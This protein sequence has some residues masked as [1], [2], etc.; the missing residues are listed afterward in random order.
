MTSADADAVTQDFADRHGRPPAGVWVAPGRVNLIGEHTDY[1]DGFVMP[2]ALAQAV[3]VAAAPR[4]DDR[5]SVTS[6]ST[7]ET[8][9]FG[10]D[11]LVPGMS[12][13]QAYVAGVVW[14]LPRPGTPSAGPTW[15]SPPTCRSARACPPP[16]PWS[17][18]CWPPSPTS[19]AWP[20]SRWSGP[21]WPGAA[22]TP[23]SGPRPA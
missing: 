16:R 5:W 20:S 2:F 8:R 9:E 19:T 7:G 11:D 21:S 6:L 3:T 13:W 22:R 14:A 17:A 1:N 23:S 12:G 15:C 4:D 10:R 18:P